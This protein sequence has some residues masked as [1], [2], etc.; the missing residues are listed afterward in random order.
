MSHSAEEQWNQRYGGDEYFY[1]TE[2]NDFLREHI[3]LIPDG[4]VLCIADGEGRNSIFV[5]SLGFNTSSVDISSSGVNKTR[6]L[7][8]ERGVVVDAHV[9]DLAV[10]DVGTSKWSAI[11]SIFCHLPQVL[12][13]EVHRRIANGLVPGGI[14][15][16]EA[17]TVNQ[18][19][20]GTGGPQVPELL[21]SEESL[22]EE[23]SG[24]E[25]IHL[26]ETERDVREGAGH[27]GLASV[28]QL[29]ARK[30]I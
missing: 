17:Y 24:L 11:V 26:A 9:G 29:I 16:L 21:M 13:G 12:R 19:G 7:A 8:A 22:R 28:V 15:L 14:V 23:F 4:R 18:I 5:A 1:G 30:T 6:L 3:A 20:R 2:P 10:F 27:T 25:I